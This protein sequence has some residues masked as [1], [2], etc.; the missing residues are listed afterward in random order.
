MLDK[1]GGVFSSIFKILT[2]AAIGLAGAR[3]AEA[4]DGSGAYALRP[5]EFQSRPSSQVFKALREAR[6]RGGRI[7]A[8]TLPALIKASELHGREGV[9]GS[10][11][12]SSTDFDAARAVAAHWS[13][14]PVPTFFQKA[15]PP[16]FGALP[17]AL[18]DPSEPGLVKTDLLTS[19]RAEFE[20]EGRVVGTNVG[21]NFRSLL[22][23]FGRAQKHLIRKNSKGAILW[24][25]GG[26]T[27]TTGHHTAGLL[28]NYFA[29]RG[30]DVISIDLPWHGQGPRE[31]F[32]SV[33]E[34]LRWVR[35]FA[36]LYMKEAGVPL[37]LAGHSMGGELAHQYMTLFPKDDLFSGVM[38]LS[39]VLDYAPGGTVEEKKAASRAHWKLISKRSGVHA[40]DMQ[41]HHGLYTKGKLTT[42]G[43][44]YEGMI[45][46]TNDW[47]PR[48]DGGADLLPS[49]CTIGQG[50]FLYVGAEKAFGDFTASLDPKRHTT[51]VYKQGVPLGSKRNADGKFPTRSIGHLT[52]DHY[53]VDNQSAPELFLDIQAFVERIIGQSLPRLADLE[54][55]AR[56][57]RGM[58][59][60]QEALNGNLITL[61]DLVLTADQNEKSFRM[62]VSVDR[63]MEKIRASRMR[64]NEELRRLDAY[65]PVY[66]PAQDPVLL[67][68]S[69]LFQSTDDPDTLI[70]MIGMEWFGNLA[71][72]EW[73]KT[74]RI[75]SYKPRASFNR[76]TQSRDYNQK[77]GPVRAWLKDWNAVSKKIKD[78]EEALPERR[79]LLSRAVKAFED[80]SSAGL[81]Q[82]QVDS[83]RRTKENQE[84]QFSQFD[85]VLRQLLADREAL[86]AKSPRNP[87]DIGEVLNAETATNLI[88]S[89]LEGL[90]GLYL[91]PN[92]NGDHGRALQTH[93][94]RAV[95]R[96][97]FL[98]RKSKI[99]REAFTAGH[100]QA[101]VL[102]RA[103]GDAIAYLSSPEIQAL[104][105]ELTQIYEEMRQLND[106]IEDAIGDFWV[107]Q[108]ARPTGEAMVVPAALKSLLAGWAAPVERYQARERALQELIQKQI[109]DGTI[110]IDEAALVKVLGLTGD[111]FMNNEQKA[112]L[113]GLFTVFRTHL[114]LEQLD[115]APLLYW[116]FEAEKQ[117]REAKL[118]LDKLLPDAADFE[119]KA[120]PLRAAYADADTRVAAGEASA[121]EARRGALAYLRENL[122]RAVVETQERRRELLRE[123]Q[124]LLAKAETFQQE[125]LHL[126]DDILTIEE[127]LY[128]D[129]PNDT[130]DYSTFTLID[131]LE[132]LD[133]SKWRDNIASLQELW[134]RWRMIWAERTASSTISAY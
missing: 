133:Y 53:A 6:L 31:M 124:R 109:S 57:Q 47:A 10:L 22:D 80:A 29:A 98:E 120:A 100:I 95:S 19:L 40:D 97:G 123:N 3:H 111:F 12:P 32:G 25:H 43:F 44:W 107:A 51:K 116:N 82:D 125:Y 34:S 76:A 13:P 58:M 28:M 20:F 36:E 88:E 5:C 87:F 18:R 91:P 27:G 102:E 26:G 126:D 63:T 71:F 79:Q 128:R 101:R 39:P 70:N 72:R 11:L 56:N 2:L 83:L 132:T 67:R 54:M 38:R 94:Q 60:L 108:S 89:R 21:V 118:A 117:R 68:L 30:I 17:A 7:P 23:N 93:I 129:Y 127:R 99:A 45:S 96:Q 15:L 86:I 52:Q 50:D 64:A 65:Q 134:R 24:M 4:H 81:P 61:N 73:A 55:E 78:K 42:L 85:G 114:G 75:S 105:L 113:E 90:K 104:R 115:S 33:H 35:R 74:T 37:F 106:K 103:L 130:F 16:G 66:D 121:L 112:A 69:D 46:T 14:A 119:A 122:A 77:L 9:G 131:L 62:E 8:R 110:Q 1:V 92:E 41:L 49:L 48:N 84:K 59:A